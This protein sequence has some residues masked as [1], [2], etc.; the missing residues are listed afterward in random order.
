MKKTL[1][2]ISNGS[3]SDPIIHSQGFPLLK[4]LSKGGFI[5]NFISV[6]NSTQ[7]IVRN[8]IKFEYKDVITFHD[9]N[10]KN[11]KFVPIWLSSFYLQ[12]IQV[13][14][15]IEKQSISILHCR[16]LFPGII[17]LLVKII[18][19]KDIKIIYDNRGVYIDEEI[20]K[21]HWKANGIKEIITRKIEKLLLK[22]CDAQVVVSNC[23]KSYIV[24]ENIREIE[25]IEKK[26]F[27]ITNGTKSNCTQILKK[28]DKNSIVGVFLG[29]AAKWQNLN[30]IIELVKASIIISKSL[31][32]KIITYNVA[33][34]EN[35]IKKSELDNN[36]IKIESLEPH[37]TQRALSTCSFGIL[38]RENN[39]INNVASPLKFA[40]YLSAGLPVLISK[41]I[42]DT[43]EIIK[44]YNV[45][46]VVKNELYEEGLKAMVELLEQE[47]IQKRCRAVAEK[48][49]NIDSSFKKYKRIYEK[50]VNSEL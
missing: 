25:D 11:I 4:S 46:V 18:F 27:V 37:E 22:K 39:L 5:C 17:A 2:F 33:V 28:K 30:G 40:E 26:T 29:S 6:E 38:L 44:K 23:F 48:E 42:G 16:S 34:Y 24:R 15:I 9:F 10:V 21:N 45:G 20:Y 50:I 7:E 14:K 41:G 32:Y 43:E 12:T 1:L 13:K 36:R 47:D 31:R 3:I 19:R 35:V 8:R 49:F